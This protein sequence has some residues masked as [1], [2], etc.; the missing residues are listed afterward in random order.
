MKPKIW[1]IIAIALIFIN[2]ILAFIWYKEVWNVHV[3][4]GKFKMRKIHFDSLMEAI[5]ENNY[6]V[7]EICSIEENKCV[8]LRKVKK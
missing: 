7:V 3:N 2:L 5:K 8:K 6:N 1:K 4:L